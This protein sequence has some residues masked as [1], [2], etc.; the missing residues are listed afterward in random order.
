MSEQQQEQENRFAGDLGTAFVVLAVNAVIEVVAAKFCIP[1]TK[2]VVWLL[3]RAISLLGGGPLTNV[4][5]AIDNVNP[6]VVVG[7]AEV[8]EGASGSAPSADGVSPE[9][10]FAEQVAEVVV[11]DLRRYGPIAQ[12]L[13]AHQR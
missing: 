12:A 10:R 4:L 2:E 13:A 3:E 1:T 8:A 7:S 6:A 11:A 9:S 5:V